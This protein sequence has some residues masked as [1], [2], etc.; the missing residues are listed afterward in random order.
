MAVQLKDDG[1]YP[2]SQKIPADQ[3]DRFVEN[4]RTPPRPS[5]AMKA[6]IKAA[7]SRKVVCR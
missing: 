7:A 4:C 2:A 3:Y 5:E 6:I 1:R